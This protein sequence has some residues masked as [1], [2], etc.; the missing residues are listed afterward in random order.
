MPGYSNPLTPA[1]LNNPLKPTNNPYM[2]HQNGPA[3]Y[4]GASTPQTGP[5]LNSN[6][7]APIGTADNANGFQLQGWFNDV[8]DAWPSQVLPYVP[9]PTTDI[10][11][12]MLAQHNTYAGATLP[13]LDQLLGEIR[14]RTGLADQY[15][16]PEMSLRGGILDQIARQ[17]NSLLEALLGVERQNRQP[18]SGAH[19]FAGF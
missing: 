18:G 14:N 19:Y 2:P 9:P 16:Q 3:Q 15:F 17:D 1:R 10:I 8:I 6:V 7:S 13:L 11:E 4:A 5:P 12:N